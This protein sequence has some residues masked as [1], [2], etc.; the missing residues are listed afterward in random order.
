MGEPCDSPDRTV[1]TAN[2]T[3][4]RIILI[5]VFAAT[6]LAAPKPQ[7]PPGI[8]AASCPN[9]PFCGPSPVGSPSQ[10]Q[11][12]QSADLAAHAAAEAAVIGRAAQ[13]LM[14]ELSEPPVTSVPPACADPPAVSHSGNR[15]PR[16]S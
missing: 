8:D 2:S 12:A 15:I 5:S 11:H 4:L 9:Y 6:V 14:V 16:V 7:L 10:A 1:V 3:M 13:L